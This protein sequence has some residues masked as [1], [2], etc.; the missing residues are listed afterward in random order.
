[1]WR[2]IT[3]LAALALAASAPALAQTG[4]AGP[5]AAPQA[6]PTGGV[7]ADPPAAGG[8]PPPVAGPQPP[9]AVQPPAPGPS[10][11]LHG[12]TQP[13]PAAPPAAPPATPVVP[14]L[15]A[16]SELDDEPRPVPDIALRAQQE[17]PLQ[18]LPQLAPPAE[19]PEEQE[20]PP[21]VVEEEPREDAAPRL[22]DTGLE[23]LFLA[24]LGAA[25]LAIGVTTLAVL[26]KARRLNRSGG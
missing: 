9:P 7:I 16:L 25:L 19:M 21:P 11:P 22:A 10:D 12:E 1:M 8:A 3:A 13:D 26:R 20:E 23:A 6:A 17:D 4:G 15:T 18:D 5:P 24:Y 14:A 2:H